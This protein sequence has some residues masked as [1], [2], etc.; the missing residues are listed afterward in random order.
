M[1]QQKQ[2]SK[3]IIPEKCRSFWIVD[4]IHMPSTGV[5]IQFPLGF[6]SIVSIKKMLYDT[7]RMVLLLVLMVVWMSAMR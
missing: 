1:E 3:Y 6:S 4:I 7:P 2:C 5:K